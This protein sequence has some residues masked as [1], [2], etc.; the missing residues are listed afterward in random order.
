MLAGQEETFSANRGN[1]LVGL[2]SVY[3][4]VVNTRLTTV[5]YNN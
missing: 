3:A 5:H 1:S 4:R 2:H